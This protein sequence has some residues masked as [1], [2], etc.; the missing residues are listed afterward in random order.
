MADNSYEVTIGGAD[1]ASYADL[2]TANGY[3]GASITATAWASASD[4]LKA[5]CLVTATRLLDRQSWADGYT[6]FDQR[7]VVDA[8]VNACCE[9]AAL[10]AAGTTDALDGATATGPVKSMKAGSVS[11]EYFASSATFIAASR[12]P[13]TVQ[14]L[15]GPYLASGA[16]SGIGAGYVGGTCEQSAF[17][18]SFGLWRGL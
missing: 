17:D 10:F 9:L 15:L 7:K 3:L 18:Q 2:P 11:L 6:T 5:Q 1:Y 12:F 14:E 4:D 13:A 16:S 8:I